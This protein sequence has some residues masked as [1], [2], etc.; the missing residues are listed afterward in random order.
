MG[1]KDSAIKLSGPEKTDN[2]SWKQSAVSIAGGDEMAQASE[3]MPTSLKGPP[4]P[5]QAQ[6]ALEQTGQGLTMGYL[7][8]LQAATQ[9]VTDRLFKMIGVGGKGGED[10]EPA[11]L[12]K[13][14]YL[15]PG[16]KTYQDLS[17]KRKISP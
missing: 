2:K 12:T 10:V 9:P 11:S 16:M 5:S 17:N 8:H 3:P 13:E 6:A 1:W 4:Q 15:N 7:P 14:D